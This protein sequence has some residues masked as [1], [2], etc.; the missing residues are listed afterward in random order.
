MNRRGAVYWFRRRVPDDIVKIVG[1]AF[2]N[3]SLGI[4]DIREAGRLARVRGVQTD[5]EIADARRRLAGETA[6]P[7]SVPEAQALAK[8]EL[9]D[10]MA[11]DAEARLMAG[12]S[13][14]E[15]VDLVLEF[16]E[17]EAREALASGDWQ[18]RAVQAAE[19]LAK[20]GRWYPEGDPSVRLMAGA[21][22]A[23]QVEWLDL[24]R[25]RQAGRVVEVG[26]PGIP[27]AQS[28]AVK[29]GG[30]TL[31]KLIDDYRR[32]R[33]ALHGLESTARKYDHIFKALEECLGRGRDIETITRADC[34]N[35]RDLLRRVP[36]HMTK[37]YPK[38]SMVEAAAAGE[39]D[40][41]SVLAPNTVT[42]YL[43]HLAAIFNWA[44]KEDLI[45]KSPAADLVKKGRANVK[46]RGFTSDEL[47]KVFAGLPDEKTERPSRYWVTALAAYSG[48]RAGELCQLAPQDVRVIGGVTCLDLSEFDADGK[49]AGAKRLKTSASERVIPV[50]P[51]VLAAGFLDFVEAARAARQERLFPELRP[52]K[53]GEYSHDLSRWFGRHMDR[54]GL[55]EPSLVFHSFRHGFK[56]A[57]RLA[58]VGD[59]TSDA[60][61]G[62]TTK[63]ISTR[64]G[65]R[66]M[67]EV[68]HRELVKV[69]LGDFR[70]PR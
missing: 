20:A 17:P 3:E 41:V 40:K 4:K 34:R 33:E 52:G 57:C 12:R 66:D 65:K 45:G 47:R 60:L 49:R 43:Q 31:G 18:P 13:A 50:H 48:A 69:A 11:T 16:V 44:V 26:A 32:E 27:A 68:L 25:E 38:L 61:G 36:V 21:L 54:I 56:D 5:Q 9:A 24:L 10:W 59:E 62:W 1:K 64:Y 51:E 35:L 22:L 29:S 46:R 67:V 37:R 7:L 42:T 19:V 8:R 6:P 70:L 14:S 39:R 2:W 58:G 15:N 63:G 30:V 53:G 23:A 28:A 55:S